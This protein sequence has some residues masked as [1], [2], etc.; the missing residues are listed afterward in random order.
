[1]PIPFTC[2]H[3]GAQTDVA[4]EYTGL[5]GPCH[6]CG[7]TITVP[8]RPAASASRGGTATA[9][10]AAKRG[11]QQL[12]TAL[13]LVGGGLAALVLLVALVIAVAAPALRRAN[14]AASRATCGDNLQRIATALQ[15]YHDVNGS[16]PPAV[17]YDAK[18]Q[19]MHSWRVLILPYLGPEGQWAAQNYDYSKPWDSPENQ[20]ALQA[21][22]S[23][24]GCPGNQATGFGE[25]SYFVVRGPGTMFPDDRPVMLDDILDGPS[26]TIAVV[27]A[28]GMTVGWTEP[29][30]LLAVNLNFQVNTGE[31]GQLGGTHLEGINV[32]LADGSVRFIREDTPAE[33]VAAMLTIANDEPVPAQYLQ[34]PPP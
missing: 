20:G 6:T 10:V 8:H 29:K 26:M 19:P 28:A 32:A 18:G 22:P 27:E 16:F 9:T 17:V 1:M 11:R 15:R 4:D 12:V 3:C 23:A 5:A 25:T 33:F 30:D 13:A 2:P 7:K 21:M 14:N 31:K 24:F 34:A